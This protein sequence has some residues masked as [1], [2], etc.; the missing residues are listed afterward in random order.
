MYYVTLIEDIMLRNQSREGTMGFL[1]DNP[2]E[3]HG[4]DA[5]ATV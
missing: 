3:I 1:S 4:I 2:V 5:V